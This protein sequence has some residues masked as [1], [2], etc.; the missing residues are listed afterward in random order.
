MSP[1][2]PFDDL[3]RLRL[4][5]QPDQ[6]PPR[7][8]GARRDRP[9]RHTRQAF[10]KGPISWPWL[11]EAASLPGRALHVGLVLWYRAGREKSLKVV[12]SWSDLATMGVKRD[13]GRRGLEQLEAAG[14][15][16]VDRHPGRLPRVK[17]LEWPAS[18]AGTSVTT[19]TKPADDT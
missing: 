14:L 18:D 10:L 11:C 12:L 9:P 16:A 15:V 7:A 8:Y 3:D 17:L 6:P 2:E 5:G 4:P 19:V 13:A 1:S